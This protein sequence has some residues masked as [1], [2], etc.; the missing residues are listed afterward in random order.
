[1]IKIHSEGGEN[2]ELFHTSSPFV[3]NSLNYFPSKSNWNSVTHLGTIFVKLECKSS[4][5]LAAWKCKTNS[6]F[7]FEENYF[8]G[9]I[10]FYGFMAFWKVIKIS[11]AGLE[12]A[13]K[14][15]WILKQIYRTRNVKVVATF[16]FFGVHKLRC[17]AEIQSPK[18]SLIKWLPN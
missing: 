11:Y 14:Q 5:W 9:E 12:K 1:M 18:F 15:H 10:T 4:F 7:G 2:T 16:W 17:L 8:L 3:W 13:E 6:V